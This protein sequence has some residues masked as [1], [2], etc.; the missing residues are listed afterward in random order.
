[1][2]DR[3]DL[4][5]GVP[6]ITLTSATTDP[7]VIAVAPIGPAGPIGATGPQGLEGPPG[8]QGPGGVGPQGQPGPQGP[9]GPTG[10]GG[11]SGATGPVGASGATGITGAA[12]PIGLTGP[13][14]IQGVIGPQ[15][16]T[17]LQGTPGTP[18]GAT[19]ATGTTGAA[20][21]AGASGTAG[22]SGATGP[23][24]ASGPAGMPSGA[25]MLFM[26]QTAPTGWTRFTNYDDCLIRV[27]GTAA[28]GAGGT[29]GFVA[30]FNSQTVTGNTTLNT[31]T[32]PAHAHAQQSNTNV[33][34]SSPKNSGY[35]AGGFAP[36]GY[37]GTTQYQGGNGAHSH[38]FYTQIK[39]ADVLIASKN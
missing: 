21:A 5:A 38:G 34:A 28:L 35:A 31:S 26:N 8:P 9:I 17:G 4:A 3:I 16:A 10:L 29:Y 12:G 1:M 18:G 15:G 33:G 7:Q 19:G 30:T 27:V 13:Q 37:G 36:T 23:Q 22:A 20:G 32:I 24:G 14:G 2:T 39:Y 11:A 6:R 25:V